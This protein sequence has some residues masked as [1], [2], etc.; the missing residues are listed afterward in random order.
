MLSK[1]KLLKKTQNK[2]STPEI[3]KLPKKKP[4]NF[5]QK[6]LHKEQLQLKWLEGNRNFTKSWQLF[7]TFIS[8]E[9]ES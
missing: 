8:Q 9:T 6:T 2:A 7:V 3:P 1:A 4:H 5:L